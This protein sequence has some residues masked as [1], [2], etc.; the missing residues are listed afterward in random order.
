[1][2]KKLLLLGTCFSLLLTGCTS[3]KKLVN[4]VQDAAVSLKA[5]ATPA[6]TATPG[7]KETKLTLGKK[8]KVGDWKICVKKAGTK[9][10]IKN[11]A[12]RIFKPKKKNSFVIITATVRNNGKK[13]ATFLPRLGYKNKMLLATLYYKGKNEYQPSELLSY[14]KDLVNLSIN[15]NASKSGI[16]V[17]DVPKKVA[18]AKGSLTLRIGTG[19]EALLYSLK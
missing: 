10:Q 8:G 1:M 4:T 19:S 12:Y 11:G 9:K 16:I 6:P 7:P 15:S 13:D 5:T 18:K 17:F 2:K 3:P 14:D